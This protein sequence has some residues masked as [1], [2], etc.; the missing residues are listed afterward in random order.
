MKQYEKQVV[1]Y[2]KENSIIQ[3]KDLKN[4]GLSSSQIKMMINKGLIKRIYRGMYSLP[5]SM[6]DPYL[7]LQLRYERLVFSHETALS[8]H[9]LTDVTPS[10]I[11]GTVP[12]NYNYQ[13]LVKEAGLNVVRVDKKRF[14]QGIEKIMSPF[15]NMITVTNMERTLCNVLL[16]RNQI[17]SRIVNEAFKNYLRSS[18]K[19]LNIL[20]RYAKLFRVEK[21]VRNYME[22]LL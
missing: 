13:Y 1:S 16:K 11:T 9:N 19:D 4:F 8:L 10:T 15:G 14:N 6:D 12:R 5:N 17:D 2:L 21:L 22:V 18:Q 20:M 7:E 3:T